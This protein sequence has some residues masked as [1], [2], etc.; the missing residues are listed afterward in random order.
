MS[1]LDKWLAVTMPDGSEWAVH[2]RIIAVSRAK[3]YTLDFDDEYERSL[4]DTIRCFEA[5]PYL[6]QDWAG[7]DM[8]W[9]DVSAHAKQISSPEPV[10]YQEGWINGDTRL[11]DTLEGAE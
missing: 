5:R 2:V 3:A 6:I 1:I 9:E 7:G 11:I 10:D 4:A 8:N